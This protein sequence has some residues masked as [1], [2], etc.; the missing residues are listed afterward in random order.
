M[1]QGNAR[2]LRDTFGIR[3]EHRAALDWSRD[4][5]GAELTGDVL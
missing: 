5:L 1:C 2:F 4:R 3:A